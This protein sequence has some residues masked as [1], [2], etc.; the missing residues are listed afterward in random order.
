MSASRR[1]E[2]RYLDVHGVALAVE[3]DGP[4]AARLLDTFY[5]LFEVTAER[6][7]AAAERVAAADLNLA[8]A[9]HGLFSIHA[10]A[11]R[12]R[13]G[14]GILL[15]G[16]AGSGKTTVALG[17]LAAGCGFAGDDCV[18]VRRDGPRLEVLPLRG[19][20]FVKTTNGMHVVD[21]AARHSFEVFRAF[22]AEALAFPAIVGG[23]TSRL[24]CLTDH[25][26]V[27]H[28]LLPSINWV[29]DRR[30]RLE[31]ADL[32]RRLVRVRAYRLL[33]GEDG[34]ADPAIAPALLEGI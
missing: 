12:N 17:A 23:R 8:L 2:D 28:S 19:K 1:Q 6:R 4:D 15:P 13:R 10:A 16:P 20:A 32:V 24:E 27:F 29:S 31:Q 9:R 33:V 3:V 7:P 14:T 22:R 26:A 21:L 5:S 30:L 25:R 18:L 11:V 34:H